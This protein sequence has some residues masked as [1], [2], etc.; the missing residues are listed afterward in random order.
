[1]AEFNDIYF[2]IDSNIVNNGFWQADFSRKKVLIDNGLRL[3]AIEK[4]REVNS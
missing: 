2:K 1:M 3:Y 4:L